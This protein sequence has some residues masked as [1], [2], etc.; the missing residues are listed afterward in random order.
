ADK[1]PISADKMLLENEKLIVEYLQEYDSITN[2]VAREQIGLKET[3]TKN[4]LKKMCEKQVIVAIGKGKGRNYI[5]N[6]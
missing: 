5:L 3:A 1:M 2:K 6:D 4:L